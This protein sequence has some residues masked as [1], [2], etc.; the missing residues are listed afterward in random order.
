MQIDPS[1]I[2][3]T[4]AVRTPI[5]RFGGSLAELSAAE[6]GAASLIESLRRARIPADRVGEV[7]IGNARQAGGGPNVA[8]QIA[9]RAGIP[10]S[11]PA[12]T[13]NQACASGLKSIILAFQE[14]VLRRRSVVAAG[15]S[16]SMSRVP[17]FVERARWGARLGNT[18][19]T[20]AMYQ[21]G[22]LCP[23][24]GILMGETAEVLAERYSIGRAEQDRYA[25]RSHERASRATKEGR[26]RSEIHPIETEDGSGHR[27]T[28]GADEHVRPDISIDAFA[29]L[30][31]VFRPKGTITAGN[32]SG[33]T[34]GAAAVTIAYGK[35][36]PS[37]GQ[38]AKS[39]G[40]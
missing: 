3:L 16:E 25:L 24:S 9:H 2:Y 17:Y 35:R 11:T 40:Y 37:V 12:F 34:D 39:T 15:G 6:L 33:I 20:D 26:L 28:L 32:A 23:L 22:F 8:R 7:I 27:N 13:V 31:A 38:I 29:R 14:I 5:G 10:F 18:R 30:P 1:A 21:D 4:G 19:L 36:A